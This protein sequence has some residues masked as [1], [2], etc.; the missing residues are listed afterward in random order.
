[1][2]P[3]FQNPVGYIEY[4]F[5]NDGTLDGIWMLTTAE[6]EVTGD[7]RASGGVPGQLKGIYDVEISKDITEE[8][9]E[10]IFKRKLVIHPANEAKGQYT[11]EWSGTN[12]K[13]GE[14]ANYVGVGM[15][16]PANKVTALWNSVPF[17]E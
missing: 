12:V 13:T 9:S 2:D 6:G 10:V 7:E 4:D 3:D 5:G 17:V 16:E 8:K 1:M 14:P 15:N 11:M